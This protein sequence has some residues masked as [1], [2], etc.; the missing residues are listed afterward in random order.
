MRITLRM[1]GKLE[2]LSYEMSSSHWNILGL[3]EVQRKNFG[4][5]STEEGHKLYFSGNK[6]KHNQGIGFLVHKDIMNTVMGCLPVS[7]R[8]ITL[9]LR[10]SPFNITIIPVYPTTLEYD[11]DAV[12]DF[13]DHLLEVLD[14]SPKKDILVVLCDWNAKVGEDAFKNWTGTCGCCCNPERNERGLRLLEFA[15]YNNLVLEGGHGTA[16]MEDT[17]TR[18]IISWLGG[19]SCGV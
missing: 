9:R 5:T 4:K 2:E 10:A 17:I 7:S 13:Y 8:L 16:Q 6:D 1:A 18:L 14:Q 15:C 3:C 11:D 12:E 19:A